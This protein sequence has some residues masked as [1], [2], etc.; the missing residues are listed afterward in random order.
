MIV[1]IAREKMKSINQLSSLEGRVA[2]VTGASGNIGNSICEAILEAKGS[3][4]MIDN[5]S[6]SLEFVSTDHEKKY[7]SK[8]VSFC[9]DLSDSQERKLLL[10]EIN[11]T[12]RYK[13]NINLHS[14]VSAKVNLIVKKVETA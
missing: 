9:S 13:I 7:D 3:L 8:I 11:K 6:E 4:I 5:N 14:E 1:E 10:Q 2:C 12:G